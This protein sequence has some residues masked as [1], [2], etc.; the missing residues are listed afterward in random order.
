MTLVVIAALAADF[1]WRLAVALGAAL[2]LAA[3][4]LSGAARTRPA[5]LIGY[6]SRISYAL[7]L[8]HFPLIL[9]TSA[10]LE[11][12][13]WRS[14]SA[15]LW[16]ALFAWVASLAAADVLHRWVEVPAAKLHRR[17]AA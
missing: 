16:G 8:V 6:L 3:P 11:S 2:V 15:G 13:G 10:L 5:R 9:L 7:F 17:L 1:R 12:N 14:T 4:G